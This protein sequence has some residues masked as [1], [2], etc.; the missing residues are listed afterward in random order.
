MQKPALTRVFDKIV[1]SSS[2]NPKNKAVKF[3]IQFAMQRV[4]KIQ[5]LVNQ[6]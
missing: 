3:L 5:L 2:L 1:W 6:N 4:R